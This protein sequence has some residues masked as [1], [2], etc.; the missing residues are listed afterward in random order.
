[1]DQPDPAIY[2]VNAFYP[3]SP[4]IA[5]EPVQQGNRR[6]L[7]VRVFPFQYN[8]VTHQLRYHPDLRIA[9]RL[10]EGASP[11]PSHGRRGRRGR[12]L[13]PAGSRCPVQA[14]CA[15]TPASK[16]STV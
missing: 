10:L 4:V 13:L 12:R 6:V 9:V 8:P 7:P 11:A 1:M 16:A 2:T 14:R 5:G 3:A 15:S